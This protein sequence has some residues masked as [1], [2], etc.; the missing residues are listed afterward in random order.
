[1]SEKDKR[2]KW[3]TFDDGENV[4]IFFFVCV[5]MKTFVVL[6]YFYDWFFAV[7]NV[8]QNKIKLEYHDTGK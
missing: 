4:E 7:F 1:M 8:Y 5:L 3:L 2:R 6:R